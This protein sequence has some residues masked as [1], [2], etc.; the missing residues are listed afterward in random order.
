M[1]GALAFTPEV[2]G[3]EVTSAWGVR[4]PRLL[5]FGQDAAGHIYTTSDD[6]SVSR[7]VLR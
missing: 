5:S 3:R 6:G 7:L 2:A 1:P 4:A